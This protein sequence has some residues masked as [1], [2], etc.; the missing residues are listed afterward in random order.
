M[1]AYACTALLQK[2]NSAST[3]TFPLPGAFPYP[4]VAAIALNFELLS[5]FP[6]QFCLKCTYP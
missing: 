4:K 6:L 1:N 2:E 3:F 5:G